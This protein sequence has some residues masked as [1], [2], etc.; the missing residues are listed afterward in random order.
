MPTNHR[1]RHLLLA[2]VGL[3][4]VAAGV[5]VQEAKPDAKKEAPAVKPA[6][7]LV[8]IV[9]GD[10]YTV[11]RE[12]IRAGTILIED[13]RIKAV[14]ETV[15]IPPGTTVV[16]AKGKTITPGFIAL[17]MSNVAVRTLGQGNNQ[18]PSRFADALNPLDRNIKFCLAAGITTGCAQV[19][20]G[21]GR[22]FGRDFDFPNDNPNAVCPCCG[23]P[24]LPTEPI[25]PQAPA[26]NR[27]RR[28]AV[29]KLTYGDLEPML[30]KEN[31]FYHLPAASLAG[32]LNRHN[33]RENVTKAKKYL[34]DQAE[35]EKQSKEGQTS[36]PPRKPVA[37]EFIQLAKKEVALR[38][39]ASSTNQI[40]DML[41][42]ARELEIDVV[43]DDVHE[44]WLLPQEL[45]A[46]NTSV[47]V[48]PRSRRRPNPGREETSGSSIELTGILE[49][50]G[51]AFAVTPLSPSVSLDGIAGRDL[52]SL[53]LEAAFA[54]RGGA[55]E[56]AALAALTIV[57]ARILG[58]ADRLGSIEVGKDADLLILDGPPLD[59]RTQV[60][61][62]IISGKVYYD[63]KVDRILPDT[64]SR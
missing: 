13:G 36:T 44:A 41:Q 8:A 58:L 31:T 3:L 57:P 43:L 63:R 45:A 37:D 40:R 50:A 14:G 30:A 17:N 47:V 64:A 61:Q 1:L 35:H 26:E 52:T 38:T 51:V 28:H 11:T 18:R 5:P 20:A 27:P 6:P 10:I 32:P 56:K 7:K 22:G 16:D 54:V 23:L 12:I 19:N 60:E 25:V 49:K 34:R 33:F 53:P 39:D 55:S 59:Y 15:T 29:L 9:G 62:A 2:A 42:M 24:I 4:S 21:P 46:A 48:T